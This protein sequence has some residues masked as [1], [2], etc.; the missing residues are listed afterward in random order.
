[1]WLAKQL[2]RM[3]ISPQGGQGPRAH[4]C[5][6]Y[7]PANRP[8]YPGTSWAQSTGKGANRNSPKYWQFDGFSRVRIF[9]DQSQLKTEKG[10]K[11]KAN[12]RS[13]KKNKRNKFDCETFTLLGINAA[14]LS[15]KLHTFDHALK[16]IKARIFFVQE[17]KQ[18]RI[19]NINTDHLKNFQ[20]FELVRQE[21]RVSGGGLMIGVDR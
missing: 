15:S 5:C 9:P 3:Q 16:N 6:E 19:G 18:S 14:G 11:R 8:D 13:L 12:R 1:M 7:W 17:V 21:Q 4:Q 2:R 20:L 10:I